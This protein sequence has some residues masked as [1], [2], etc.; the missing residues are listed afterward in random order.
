MLT[1]TSK[2]EVL[3]TAR[4][5]KLTTA[6]F[7]LASRMPTVSEAFSGRSTQIIP[8]QCL[9][10]LPFHKKQL[11]PVAFHVFSSLAAE[12]KGC[13]YPGLSVIPTAGGKKQQNSRFPLFGAWTGVRQTHRPEPEG[14][15]TRHRQSQAAG[16]QHTPGRA[17]GSPTGECSH[18]R[19]VLLPLIPQKTKREKK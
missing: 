17:A 14:A 11:P 7:Q 15:N 12:A 4:T 16:P 3:G 19:D 2:G 13:K 8:E 5:K 6:N 18:Q 9:V 1:K 10:F